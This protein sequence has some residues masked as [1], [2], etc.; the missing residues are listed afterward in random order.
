MIE[1]TAPEWDVCASILLEMKEATVEL[2]WS[3]RFSERAVHDPKTE[4]TSGYV[5]NT[6]VHV[7]RFIIWDFFLWLALCWG[8][9]FLYPQHIQ[10]LNKAN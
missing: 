10:Y 3:L 6:S 2:L 1:H 4:P 7:S 8:F 9:F 5:K